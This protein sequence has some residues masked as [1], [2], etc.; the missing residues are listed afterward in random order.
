VRYCFRVAD[1]AEE[2][3]AMY[4]GERVALPAKKPA[5][6]SIGRSGL[7]YKRRA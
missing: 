3:Q 4:G 2:F 6:S 7:W 1:D 5:T